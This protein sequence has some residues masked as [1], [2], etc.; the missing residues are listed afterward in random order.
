MKIN[1]SFFK[2][3]TLALLLIYLLIYPIVSFDYGVT[4]D[5]F[6]HTYQAKRI[7]N[8]YKTGFQD[9]SNI[10]ESIF[11]KKGERNIFL[12][13][14]SFDNFCELVYQLLPFDVH[15]HNLRHI[16]GALFGVIGIFF[17]ALVVRSAGAGWLGA[18]LTMV[19]FGL[20]APRFT[21]HMINNLK[22]AP[23]AVGYIINIY[24][25]IRFFKEMPNP[26]KKSIV[27]L[28]GSLAFLLSVR[29]GGLLSF[30]YLG[31][32]AGIDILFKTGLKNLNF[33]T[34]SE[35]A[36][37]YLKYIFPI[38]LCGYFLGLVFWPYGL[39]NPFSAPFKSLT[40]F[41]NFSVSIPQIFEGAMTSSSQ[42]PWY[43]LIKY[44]GITMP[45][46]TLLGFILFFPMAWKNREKWNY[47]I[48]FILL[49][50]IVF[51]IAYI[52][53]KEAN[54]YGGWRHVL[55]VAPPLIALSALGWSALFSSFSSKAIKS[56]A[57]LA[58]VILAFFPA[59]YLIA[60]H[61]YGVVYFNELVGGVEGAYGK[62]EMDYYGSSLQNCVKWLEE[63][64]DIYNRNT[65]LSIK[66]NA[67]RNLM[68]LK[69]F[70]ELER[71]LS[72]STKVKYSR[73]PQRSQDYW[74]IAIWLNQYIPPNQLLNKTYPPENVLYEASVGDA[75][76]AVV[77]KRP[78]Y[79]DYYGFQDLNAGKKQEAIEHF[80]NY[81]K[82]DQKNETV[83]NALARAYF[84]LNDFQKAA[85]AAGSAIKLDNSQVN[86]YNIA[87][88]SYL[89]LKDYNNA[90]SA[91]NGMVNI[92]P[93]PSG[94]YYLAVCYANLN[95]RNTAL[96]YVNNALQMNP[97]FKEARQLKQQLSGGR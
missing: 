52:I 51:P 15:I 76:L 4:G 26:T 40:E 28:I 42:L 86:A 73:Y 18:F 60:N 50:A 29:S 93:N 7:V 87:G 31:L 84:E 5:E 54:V 2:P 23:F 25:M 69:G 30:A 59:K 39:E 16:L 96:A 1:D 65:P 53:Y 22:D 48:L 37:S 20:A 88:L 56:V 6:V 92:Q 11:S 89:N 12:Y 78:S 27:L 21:G 83:Y 33:N 47:F 81:I 74:D 57:G 3:L 49:F 13:G 64:E 24:A 38:L 91:F 71:H 85:R 19:I 75:V 58:F 43:Y 35:K 70:K 82:V 55:F 67:A 94:Y 63:N 80:N 66:T 46:V 62:Y 68:Y 32:F 77:V 14:Q 9:K 34:L 44:I 79:E 10:N 36:I 61:P 41:S 8:Y 90:I 45:I 95:D 17:T 97:N 72:D